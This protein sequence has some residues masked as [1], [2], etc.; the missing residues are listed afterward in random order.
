MDFSW[1]ISEPK[2]WSG[3]KA[4]PLNP[5]ISLKHFPAFGDAY[6]DLGGASEPGMRHILWRPRHVLRS[7][8]CRLKGHSE[9]VALLGLPPE[10][11]P[12]S[13]NGILLFFTLTAER[14]TPGGLE[15][16]SAAFTS[17]KGP[18]FS[19]L[20]QTQSG[21]NFPSLS[22]GPMNTNQPSASCLSKRFSWVYFGLI[23]SIWELRTKKKKKKR[24]LQNWA[25][26]T[27]SICLNDFKSKEVFSGGFY[28]QR[29]WVFLVQDLNIESHTETQKNEQIR[30][31][32]IINN[33][34]TFL[35]S[36][37]CQKMDSILR[38]AGAKTLHSHFS[39]NECFTSKYPPSAS[40]SW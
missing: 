3:G 17:F 13:Q 6:S 8:T 25:G 5:F 15:V 4:P 27:A 32:E 21:I 40:F 23:A 30:S 7:W 1:Y 11:P 20:Q 24:K 37:H 29:Y 36:R 26:F 28:W 18:L 10:N 12:Q 34:F 2:P 31:P 14:F 39:S 33:T 19:Q 16:R 9:L 22:A 38:A 35:T